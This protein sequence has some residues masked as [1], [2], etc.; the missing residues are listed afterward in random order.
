MPAMKPSAGLLGVEGVLVVTSSPVVLVEG[1]HVG[2]RAAGVDAD[3]DPGGC[4]GND[5]IVRRLP[6]TTAHLADGPA[7]RRQPLPSGRGPA[8]GRPAPL[9]YPAYPDPRRWRLC[10]DRGRLDRPV[11]GRG[12]PAPPDHRAPPQGALHGRERLA[13]AVGAGESAG[14][15]P[16]HGDQRAPPR[17]PGRR[18]RPRPGGHRQRR[19]T[20]RARHRRGDRP[21]GRVAGRGARDGAQRRRVDPRSARRL[22]HRVGRHPTP[23]AGPPYRRRRATSDRSG[24]S[25]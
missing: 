25:V 8:P 16:A 12:P 24:S 20:G 10:H 4:H 6:R 23:P 3:P 9:P 21:A 5:S 15:G 14:T 17:R 7:I 1:D 11:R 19:D 2:E 13:G 18:A 22:R